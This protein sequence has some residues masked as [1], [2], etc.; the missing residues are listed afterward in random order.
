[1]ILGYL[2][3]A[4]RVND[5]RQIVVASH[6]VGALAGRP[7]AQN[8][9]QFLV[10]GRRLERR[11]RR[12]SGYQRRWRQI[13]AQLG[14]GRRRLCWSRPSSSLL[15]GSAGPRSLLDDGLSLRGDDFLGAPVQFGVLDEAVAVRETG[16]A[17]LAAVSLLSL[18]KRE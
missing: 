5:C 2:S 13:Q 11:R 9:Q 4:S 14:R 10:F 7:L 8:L 18:R 17:L 1:M 6:V 16:A 15:L 3:Y 12:K